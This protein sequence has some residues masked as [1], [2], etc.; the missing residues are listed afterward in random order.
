LWVVGWIEGGVDGGWG[1]YREINGARAR[2][3]R[4]QNYGC[5][6]LHCTHIE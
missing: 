6:R 4:R 1:E 2:V 5:T 3:C